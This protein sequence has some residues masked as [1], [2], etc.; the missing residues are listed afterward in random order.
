MYVDQYEANSWKLDNRIECPDCGEYEC[1]CCGSTETPKVYKSNGSD[2]IEKSVE[3]SECGN[4][5]G[6]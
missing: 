2:G 4:E 1:E 5:K 3:C 6:C